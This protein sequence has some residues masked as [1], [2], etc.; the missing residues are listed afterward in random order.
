MM[1]L[2]FFCAVAAAQNQQQPDSAVKS[3]APTKLNPQ[4]Q[5]SRP[6]K[7]QPQKKVYSSHVASARKR[8]PVQRPVTDILPT[9]C[10][11]SEYV[12]PPGDVYGSYVPY[13]A[14]SQ[15][16]GCTTSNAQ[17]APSSSSPANSSAVQKQQP[18]SVINFTPLNLALPA[19]SLA[20][21]ASSLALPAIILAQPASKL[22]QPASSDLALAPETA[23]ST[24]DSPA[25]GGYVRPVRMHRAPTIPQEVRPFHSLAIGFTASTLGAGIEFAIP[26]AYRLNLRSSV[27][28]F[29][30]NDPFSIDGVDYNARLHLKSSATSVDWFPRGEGGFHI[31]PGIMYVKNTLS[32]PASV[33]PGKTFV[34]GSQTFINS[35]DDPVSGYSSVVYSRKYAPMLL[36]GFG[37]IIPRSGRHLSL[38]IEFGAAYTG[39]PQINVSL[40]GTACTTSG[41][42]D[43][44]TNAEA[45]KYLKQEINILNEDLKK[46]PV[47][48]I[49]SLGLAY[50][51]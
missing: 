44:A 21:P 25:E 38:P 14:P 43:F 12:V 46:F 19:S 33:G 51:F 13:V 27:N 10:T 18:D 30:F 4:T 17:A 15:P 5:T 47:F 8:A 41:C 26:M 36:V 20:L 34:L 39:P 2:A 3:T 37:N 9:S 49:V 7:T 32:A 31:S 16:T 23:S 28:F 11:T 35:V 1:P 24:G 22:A 40:G 48:P 42:V 50:H 6:V 29:A 45:Q